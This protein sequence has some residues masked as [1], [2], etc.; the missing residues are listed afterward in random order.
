M[1]QQ[2]ELSTFNNKLGKC[3]FQ[4]R[5]ELLKGIL[6]KTKTPETITVSR[7]IFKPPVFQQYP[8]TRTRWRTWEERRVNQRNSGSYFK[9]EITLVYNHGQ[10]MIPMMKF[11]QQT[12]LPSI[13]TR[14]TRQGEESIQKENL[15]KKT[16][17]FDTFIYFA[18]RKKCPHLKLFWSVFPRIRTEY[19][20]I[21]SISLIQ[22]GC[23]KIQTRITLNL[24]IFCTVLTAS[25][26]HSQ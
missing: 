2:I 14:L 16:A 4:N 3:S 7:V 18:L 6:A 26:K 10:R 20:E 13:L 9:P 22:S 19:G 23:G 24:D 17:T 21:R 1:K 25:Y 5:E 8:K 12:Y 15:V 11:L